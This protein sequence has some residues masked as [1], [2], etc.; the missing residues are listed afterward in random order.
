MLLVVAERSGTPIQLGVSH[1]PPDGRSE[2]EARR[3]TSINAV[4]ERRHGPTDAAWPREQCHADGTSQQRWLNRLYK[5]FIRISL[6]GWGV[7]PP[8]AN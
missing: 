8:R 4:N 3:Q 2:Q 7:Q 6:Q 5:C 1:L